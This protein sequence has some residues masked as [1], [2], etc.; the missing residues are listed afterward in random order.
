[1]VE[2]RGGSL[3]KEVEGRALYGGKQG[4]NLDTELEC[5]PLFG[6]TQGREVPIKK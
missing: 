2:R 6:G 1:M 3:N 5:R 4:G